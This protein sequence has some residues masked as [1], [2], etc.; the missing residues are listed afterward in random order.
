MHMKKYLT[1]LFLLT[2]LMPIVHGQ[3]YQSYSDDFESYSNND[4]LAQTSKIWTTWS[5]TPS[6][7]GDDV[8]VT[9]S[10]SYSGK[11]SIYFNAGPGPEDVVL[12]FGGVHNEGQ[13]VFETMMKVPAGKSAYF[14]FQ[15]DATIGVTWAVEITFQTDSNVV[16]SN[17]TSGTMFTREY[18]QGSWFKFKMYVNLTKNEWHLYIDDKYQGYFANSQNQVSMLDI[19]PADSDASF[20]MDDISFIYAPASPDNAGVEELTSPLNPV[21]GENDLKV[22]LVNNGNNIIDSVRVFWSLDGVLQKTVHVNKTI[23]T[24]F[25]TAGNELEVSLDSKVSLTKGLHTIKAWT[26]YPNGEKDTLN[27]DDT[28]ITTFRAEV[29]GV[30][31]AY[32]KPF[33]GK[34]G[35]GTAAWPDTVCA[36]DTLTYS[37]TPPSGYTNADL[38]KGWDIKSFTIED[39]NK[40]APVDTQSFKPTSSSDYK[41]RYVADTSEGKSTFK[42]EILVS[43]GKS[44][45]DTTVTRYFYVE[46]QPHVAFTTADACLGKI[47]N[48]ANTSK[49]GASNDY[50][51][52]FGDNTTSKYMNTAKLYKSPGTYDAS[53]I[54]TAP[55]GCKAT[56]TQ[57]VTVHD[58]PVAKFSAMDVCDSNNVVFNDSTT[59]TNGSIASYFWEFGDGD[60]SIAQNASHLYKQAGVYDVSL[61]VTSD[62]GCSIKTKGQVEVHPVPN[63]VFSAVNSCDLDSVV[64]SNATS[65]GGSD[66]L[67]Y[68]WDFGDMSQ[69]IKENPSHLYSG[70]GKYSVGLKVTTSNGCVDSTQGFVEVYAI[71]VA[72]FSVNN[73][74]L[75]DSTAFMNNST[76]STGSITDY[77]WTFG[78]GMKATS[79]DTILKYSKA[80]TFN[81]ELTVTG[82]GGCMNKISKIAEVYAVPQADFTMSNVCQDDEVVFE[83][84][85]TTTT[86]TI[87]Y[88]WTLGDG[89]TSMDQ[90]PKNTYTKDGIYNVKLVAV[91]EDGCADSIEKSIEIYP[92]PDA[93][94]TY[95]DKGFMQFDFSPNDANLVS[96]HWDFGDGDTSIDAS[97][98]HE[99]AAEGSYDVTLST[100]DSNGCSSENTMKISVSTGIA[101]VEREAN[102]FKVYPNPFKEELNIVYELQNSSNVAIEIYSL[103]GKLLHGVMSQEQ[104]SGK[105]QYNFDT[106]LTSG[107]YIL[108]MIIDN[109]V[110]H[111]RIIKAQ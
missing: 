101:K 79:K 36:G 107:A 70:P 40:L 82:T 17:T 5:G 48:F 52:R 45:C 34:K 86:D 56:A 24:N 78:G 13:F 53:L 103:N 49:G 94:F 74:C 102:P 4:W 58:I 33:Q 15:A 16:F 72:D 11:N 93:E 88:S 39:D 85:S 55:S 50:L 104:S 59:I 1:L 12:P 109:N 61:T 46:P 6:S 42:I 90:N 8:K 54:A 37:L 30:E 27:F 51:W 111:Q 110:Y 77:S 75:G 9:N 44:G 65:Y 26:A 35:A 97:P 18:P 105:Y 31:I 76:I 38:G 66:M 43:I 29:R 60:S 80:G 83:N 28:L 62:F 67:S 81:V 63:A 19:Y 95:D 99:Y 84:Q 69:S 87:M 3:K 108:R 14:N 32:S 2:G 100:V 25:S 92:L 41:L 10:D 68:E 21:C 98:Y 89:T 106:Q 64:F 57:T 22:L 47:V 71:P 20:W 73:A 23:D 7:T 96:Y 91:S